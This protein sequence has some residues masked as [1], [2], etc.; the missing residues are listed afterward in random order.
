MKNE[1]HTGAVIEAKPVFDKEGRIRGVLTN[2]P[3]FDY[4]PR[5]GVI[6]VCYSAKLAEADAK[7]PFVPFLT[8]VNMTGL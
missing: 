5:E 6:I 4:L 8:D 7:K 1:K 3:G 2:D